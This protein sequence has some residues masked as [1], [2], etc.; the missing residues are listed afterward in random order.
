MITS[1]LGKKFLDAFNLSNST[2]YNARQFFFEKFYPLFFNH[3]KY[4]MSG[5]NSPFENPKISWDDMLRGKKPIEP[6]DKR[7][8]RLEKFIEKVETNQAEMSIAVGYPSLDL[9]ATTSGQISNIKAN[10]TIDDIYL[11]WIGAGLGVGVQGGLSILFDHPQI[12]LD[13]YEG[14]HYY[15]DTLNKIPL[16]KGNQVNTWNGQWIAHRYSKTYSTAIPTANFN[17]YTT[18]DEIISIE[19]QSWTK[20]LLGIARSFEAAQMMGY[21]Y[22]LGQTNTTVGFIPFS[23]IQ[24]RR[25][26][27]LYK[28]FFGMDGL[29]AEEL[30]GTAFGFIKA[31]QAGSIGIKAMEPKGLKEYLEFGKLPKYKDDENEKIKFNTYQIWILAMLN[32]E[33]L[34]AKAQEFANALNAYS[35]SSNN[36]KNTKTNKVL[37]VLAST[38]KKNFI[39]SLV[40]VVSETEEK[41]IMD[42]AGIVNSMPSDNVPYFLTLIRF[43]YA[44]INK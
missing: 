17:P 8:E 16:L 30:Y 41:V 27:D 26:I 35:C 9:M 31:C 15:R 21:V 28:R 22:N 12:L 37:A 19:T 42:I 43:H 5:G 34:W 3:S 38:T 25:A 44:A 2:N 11:S 13:I 18:K 1:V 40:E 39:E 6:I 7:K 23:L 36:A 10:T 14:W 24:I 4:M 20:V 32:N 29:K 33:Q